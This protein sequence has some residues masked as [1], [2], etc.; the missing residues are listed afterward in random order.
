[1]RAQWSQWSWVHSQSRK[2]QKAT[3]SKHDMKSWSVEVLK[4]D[5]LRN[6]KDDLKWFDNFD[7]ISTCLNDFHGFVS[8]LKRIL[9]HLHSFKR[10]SSL[11][12][13]GSL[14]ASARQDTL[15]MSQY[16]YYQW[17]LMPPNPKTKKFNWWVTLPCCWS[18]MM[19]GDVFNCS[20]FVTFH[21]RRW[22]FLAALMFPSSSSSCLPPM[23]YYLW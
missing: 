12:I 15:S 4:E 11:P 14:V 2:C 5:F 19:D 20:S 21:K 18:V 9:N 13:Q 3:W 1:M 16:Q 8:M 17:N 7:M 22:E 10:S 6:V 23:A